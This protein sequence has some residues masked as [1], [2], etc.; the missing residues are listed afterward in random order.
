MT[1]EERHQLEL[2]TLKDKWEKQKEL[3][4]KQADSLIAQIKELQKVNQQQADRIRIKSEEVRDCKRALEH[5]NTNAALW[6]ADAE[7]YKML[8]QMLYECT[9]QQQSTDE[10]TIAELQLQLS[11][12]SGIADNCLKNHSTEEHRATDSYRACCKHA[13]ELMKAYIQVSKEKT[14]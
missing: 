5:E 7:K 13:A 14:V 2:L 12:N 4:D 8:Y 11:V 6:K 9:C 3:Y 1:T 10:A